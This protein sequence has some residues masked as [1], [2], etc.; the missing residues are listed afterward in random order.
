MLYVMKNAEKHHASGG[1]KLVIKPLRSRPKL[2]E[3]FRD[4]NWEN[5]S[6][7]VHAIQDE[8]TVS[9]SLEQLYRNVEDVC[10]QNHADWLYNR[11]EEECDIHASKTLELITSW[12]SLEAMPF[13]EHVKGTWERYCSQLILIRQVFMYL[14]RTY[15]LTK[16]EHRSTFDMGLSYFRGHLL[17]K[18]YKPVEEKTVLGILSI[19]DAEREGESIDRHLLKNLVRMFTLLGL[20]DSSFMGLFFDR[21]EAFYSRESKHVIMVRVDAFMPLFAGRLFDF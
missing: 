4:A 17:D 11:L 1:K 2:P 15:L 14:D 12:L 9:A 5:L 18:Q 8:R 21:V 20:Y 13:L 3:N 10:M 16:S 19:I 6:E 7:A